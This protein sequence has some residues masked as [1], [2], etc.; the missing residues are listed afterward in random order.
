MFTNGNNV[1]VPGQ[2]GEL[3]DIPSSISVKYLGSNSARNIENNNIKSDNSTSTN[4]TGSNANPSGS[5]IKRDEG[6]SVNPE[7]LSNHQDIEGNIKGLDTT[8][9]SATSAKTPTVTPS[10]NMMN[11]LFLGI[12]RTEDREKTRI[13]S[14]A[15]T[16]MLARIDLDNR[17]MKVLSIPRDTY[18]YIPVT[19]TTDKINSSY[20]YGALQGKAA[21][22]IKDAILHLLGDLSKIDYFFTLDMETVPDIIDDLGGLEVNVEIDM[23]SHGVNLL[24]GLQVLDGK[25]A[26][27]YI[28][29]RYADDGDIGRIRRQQGFIKALFRKLQAS[30]IEKELLRII[31]F[32]EDYINTDLGLEQIENIIHF[33]AG[34][35]EEGIR[36]F[37][38]PGEG[39]DMNGISYW[40]ID[41]KKMKEV[42]ADFY[43]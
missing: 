33:C 14:A 31:L 41:E 10:K 8:N 7:P 9:A 19:D 38:L 28:R 3:Q 23:Q 27:D 35:Q 11:I 24:K 15:D 1:S 18:T 22:S 39:K 36:F 21:K 40:I 17:T 25:L 26:Y 34:F 29:W 30:D 16:I 6:V 37:T 12:D 2:Q 43:D 5:S 32:Y 42:L 20:A 13:S 4:P